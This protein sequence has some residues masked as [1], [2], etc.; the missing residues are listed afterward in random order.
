LQIIPFKGEY[1][2]LSEEKKS[3]VKG[4][5]YPVCDLRYPFLG[6]HFTPMMNGSVEIGPNAVLSFSR[7]KYQKLG[8]EFTEVLRI[9][10]F[11]GFWKMGI[12]NTKT[13]LYEWFRSFSKK[14]F[15]RD[16]Q[17][18]VPSIT[19]KDLKPGLIGLR[20]QVVSQKGEIIYD[21]RIEEKKHMIHILNAP[22]PAATASFAIGKDIANRAFAHL[23]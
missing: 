14:R 10:K 5:I 4:L 21:F 12:Q 13:G 2:E 22:S 8:V 18:L 6:I 20:A 19:E 23:S 15:V 11:P 1:Y 17:K 3:L 16:A 9:L 7:S